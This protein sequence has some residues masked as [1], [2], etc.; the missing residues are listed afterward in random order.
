MARRKEQPIRTPQWVLDELRK[1]NATAEGLGI[2]YQEVHAWGWTSEMAVRTFIAQTWPEIG[3]SGATQRTR[4]AWSKLYRLA[5]PRGEDR[6]DGSVWAV[7]WYN[8]RFNE[9]AMGAPPRPRNWSSWRRALGDLHLLGH[10]VAATAEEAKQIAMVTLGPLAMMNP[11][12]LT[13]DRIGPGGEAR[14]RLENAKVAKTLQD[15]VVGMEETMRM[16][17]WERDQLATL[18]QFLVEE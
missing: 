10:V 3:K 11:D 18:T 16:I 5:T 13:I 17:A 1:P 12:C 9:Q 15:Q 4:K 8:S 7:R 14:V 6:V 2:T